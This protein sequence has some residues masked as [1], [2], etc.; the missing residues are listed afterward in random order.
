MRVVTAAMLDELS[1]QVRAAHKRVDRTLTQLVELEA[2]EN[3]A[4]IGELLNRAARQAR[5]LA[6]ATEELSSAARK[7]ASR[8]E[9]AP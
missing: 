3:Q 9:L 6:G 1:Q 4:E 7:A 2:G 5:H 8:G